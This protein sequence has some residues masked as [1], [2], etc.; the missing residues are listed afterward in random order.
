MRTQAKMKTVRLFKSGRSQVV[1]LPKEFRFDGVTEV[2]IRR[3]GKAVI[4]EPIE[5][6]AWDR[7]WESWQPL[8]DEWLPEGRNQQPIERQDLGLE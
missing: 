7:W 6:F 3:E 8:G 1:C 5:A 4:L 2:S